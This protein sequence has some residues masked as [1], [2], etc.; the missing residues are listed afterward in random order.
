MFGVVFT[1]AAIGARMIAS[2]TMRMA[3]TAYRPRRWRA[4][5]AALHNP[6]CNGGAQV[7][8]VAAI[9]SVGVCLACLFLKRCN[10]EPRSDELFGL[11]RIRCGERRVVGH[12]LADRGSA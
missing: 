10:F 4:L 8:V 3:I 2:E 7:V 5:S 9:A 11:R 12:D 6:E 1:G